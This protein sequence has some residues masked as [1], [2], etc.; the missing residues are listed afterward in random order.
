MTN[1]KIVL[2]IFLFSLTGCTALTPDYARPT[3]DIPDN[4]KEDANW[5]V[6][7]PNDAFPK[8][9][10]WRVFKN[11]TLNEL[12]EE[13]DKNQSLI[14]AAARVKEARSVVKFN[15]GEIYPS[16]DFNPEWTRTGQSGTL[17]PFALETQVFN[18]YKLPFEL[19][20]ELDLWGRVR[21]S[22]EAAKEEYKASIADFNN[23]VL[24]LRAELARNYFTLNSL[25]RE[26][27]LLKEHLK[28]RERAYGIVENLYESGEVS[29]TDLYRA[30][31]EMANVEVDVIGLQKQRA[32]VEHAI[33]VLVGQAPSR[34]SLEPQTELMGFPRIPAGLPSELLERRPDV[35]SAERK[36]A[37]TNA[38][39]GVARAAFF[40][41]ITLTGD[42]GFESGDIDDIVAWSSRAWSIGPSVNFPIFQGGRNQAKLQQAKAQ[43]EISMA[44]Y[45]QNI[46]VAFQEVEDSLS[47]LRILEL[48]SSAVKRSAHAATSASEASMK[49]Y[50]AGLV[51]FLEVV[52]AQRVSLDAQRQEVENI[53]QR[54]ITTVLLIKALGG[55]WK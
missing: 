3:L 17:E 11:D 48:Q 15:R 29:Q 42:A 50:R 9:D 53:K 18:D 7:E 38:R 4:Y 32:E 43:Y 49:R 34:F 36:M 52:D 30:E 31:T 21:R 45:R 54:L 13:V 6:A 47:G 44:D 37:A 20:Y 8:G 12:Q 16:V 2:M 14:G 10:W 22:V 35:A 40:P 24:S 28:I 25:D 26:I 19:S 23:V 39:I 41:K 51:S 46:L 33:A 5:K 27:L 1:N 55:G